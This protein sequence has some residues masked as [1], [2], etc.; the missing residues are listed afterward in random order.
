MR[1]KLITAITHVNLHKKYD[2]KSAFCSVNS[3]FRPKK[4][5]LWVI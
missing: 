2:V 5:N 4:D 3:I 1:H